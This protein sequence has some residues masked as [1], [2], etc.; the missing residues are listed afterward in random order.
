MEDITKNTQSV[1]LASASLSFL[2]LCISSRHVHKNKRHYRCHVVRRIGMWDVCAS[3]RKKCAFLPTERLCE[4][5]ERLTD[6]R[7]SFS[8]VNRK[9]FTMKLCDPS[10]PTAPFASASSCR[11]DFDGIH[12]ETIVDESIQQRRLSP[13]AYYQ[14]MKHRRLEKERKDC[15]LESLSNYDR[16]CCLKAAISEAARL[17]RAARQRDTPLEPQGG[18]SRRRYDLSN[19]ELASVIATDARIL[20]ETTPTA[21]SLR[22]RPFSGIED[23]YAVVQRELSKLALWAPSP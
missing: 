2:V 12:S 14:Q 10:H 1:V 22:E 15:T 16:L 13:A 20:M 18:L 19:A 8:L 9:P 3:T 4:S 6:E 5:K 21:N 23:N 7:L 17:H 11:P